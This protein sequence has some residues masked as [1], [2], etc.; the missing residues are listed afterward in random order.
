ME[1]SCVTYAPPEAAFI[2]IYCEMGYELSV[3]EELR[4]ITGITEIERTIGNYDIVAKVE[5]QSLETL[6][7]IIAF[8]IRRIKEVRSTTTLMCIDS[9]LPMTIQ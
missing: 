9:T 4:S 5:V 8:K 3:E 2:M 7:D 6:R 1:K